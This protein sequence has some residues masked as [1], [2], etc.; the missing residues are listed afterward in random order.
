MDT[1][2][3]VI[4]FN[5]SE[6]AYENIIDDKNRQIKELKEEN[7][8]LEEGLKGVYELQRIYHA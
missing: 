6:S 5:L 4:N 3:A 7:R 8:K 2:G 1:K